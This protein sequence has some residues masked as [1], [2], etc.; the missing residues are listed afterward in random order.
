MRVIKNFKWAMH[1]IA[2][3]LKTER[4]FRL[5]ILAAFAAIILGWLF[6]LSVFEW[7]LLFFAIGLVLGLELLNT[8]LERF[9]DILRPRLDYRVK[10]MK[11]IMAGAVFVVSL[12]AFAVG[13]FIFLPHLL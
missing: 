11:D 3:A 1:G 8:A 6:D 10:E 13:L 12:C 4:T 7:G 5:Q 9:V 2:G